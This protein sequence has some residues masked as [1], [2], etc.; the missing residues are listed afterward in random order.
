MWLRFSQEAALE[1]VSGVKTSN[2]YARERGGKGGGGKVHPTVGEDQ[3]Q[4][5]RKS[6][7]CTF[8]KG[9]KGCAIL[10]DMLCASGSRNKR[11][12]ETMGGGEGGGGGERSQF[13]HL[14]AFS[15]V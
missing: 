13:I 2:S 10:V 11:T 1:H 9:L 5:T 3:K 7:K 12:D 15:G 6:E 8:Q 14:F 4:T